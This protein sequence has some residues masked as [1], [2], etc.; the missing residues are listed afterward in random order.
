MASTELHEGRVSIGIEE[1]VDD[2]RYVVQL[3]LWFLLKNV[4]GLL[5]ST[6]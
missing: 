3:F 5:Q 6:L 2:C 4:S 1:G